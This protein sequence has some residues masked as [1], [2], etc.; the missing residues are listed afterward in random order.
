MILSAI[1]LKR[2]KASKIAVYLRLTGGTPIRIFRA[3]LEGV[4]R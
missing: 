4:P 3:V 1:A 2:Q